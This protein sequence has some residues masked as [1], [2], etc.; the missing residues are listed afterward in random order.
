MLR[1]YLLQGWFIVTYGLG[2]YLLNLFIGFLSPSIDPE[3]DDGPG[4]PS[5]TGEEFRPFERRVPEFKFWYSASKSVCIATVMTFF[6]V[7]DIPVFWPILLLYFCV[8]F[9]LTMKRQIKHMWKHKYV[10]W[11]HGKK[12]YKGKKEA[13]TTAA[14]VARFN[15]K[16]T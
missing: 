9:F 1:V 15:S 11:S 7:F 10:P 4:L 6:S 14:D 8:L 13:V 3:G 2:I 12:K 5:S 16:A